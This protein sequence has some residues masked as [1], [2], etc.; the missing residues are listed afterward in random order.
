MLLH[1]FCSFLFIR[2]E[3]H[4]LYT[5]QDLLQDKNISIARKNELLYDR[6]HSGPKHSRDFYQNPLLIKS[7]KDLVHKQ[8][9]W[10]ILITLPERPQCREKTLTWGNATECPEHILHCIKIDTIRLVVINASAL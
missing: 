5:V 3:I 7:L 9:E 10:W 2:T 4:F 8:M 6:F 1:S